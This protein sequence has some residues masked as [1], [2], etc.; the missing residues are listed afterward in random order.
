M[1][2]DSSQTVDLQIT[3]PAEPIK[4]EVKIGQRVLA[5][6]VILSLTILLSKVFK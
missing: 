1:L 4:L 2:L 5:V 3:A 6:A